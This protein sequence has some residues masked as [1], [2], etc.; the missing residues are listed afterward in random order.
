MLAVIG[1]QQKPKKGPTKPKWTSNFKARNRECTFSYS[2]A[3]QLPPSLL[4]RPLHPSLLHHVDSATPLDPAVHINRLH[5]TASSTRLAPPPKS[6]TSSPCQNLQV[7]RPGGRRGGNRRRRDDGGRVGLRGGSPLQRPPSRLAP[8]LPLPFLL[9]L[10]LRQRQRHA[11]RRAGARVPQGGGRDQEALRHRYAPC[12]AV[13]ETGGRLAYHFLSRSGF[14][15]L[16]WF[17]SSGVVRCWL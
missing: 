2:P 1:A 12:L 11:R 6:P 16:V 9:P 5:A 7:D 14:F 10:P 3:L 15:P 13:A 17:L 4:A 8:P